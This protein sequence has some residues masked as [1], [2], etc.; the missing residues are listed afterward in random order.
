MTQLL[1]QKPHR[2]DTGSEAEE[3]TDR[4]YKNWLSAQ[5]LLNFFTALAEGFCRKI[6]AG[7]ALPPE[8]T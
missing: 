2:E 3:M 5:G 8:V 7:H 4:V 1:T 6:L